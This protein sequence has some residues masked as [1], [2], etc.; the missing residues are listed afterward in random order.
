MHTGKGEV[1]NSQ[2]IDTGLQVIDPEQADLEIKIIYK[3]FYKLKSPN[4]A[5]I[6]YNSTI[7]NS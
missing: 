3:Q 4:M 5:S 2:R 6:S 7:F 1:V